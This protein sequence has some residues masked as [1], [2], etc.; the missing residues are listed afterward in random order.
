MPDDSLERPP[1]AP[2][3]AVLV[4][5]VLGVI[6]VGWVV[7]TIIAGAKFGLAVAVVGGL[8]YGVSRLR[9]SDD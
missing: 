1:V 7:R 3:V 2:L 4:A 9:S 6:V 5:V 8:I